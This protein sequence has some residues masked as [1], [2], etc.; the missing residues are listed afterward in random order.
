M[1]R[2]GGKG[3]PQKTHREKGENNSK[4]ST[5]A[6]EIFQ[7]TAIHLRGLGLTTKNINTRQPRTN[8]H[9]IGTGTAKQRHYTQTSSA[10]LK[11][12]EL[13]TRPCPLPPFSPLLP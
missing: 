10:D 11:S 3:T 9:R 4:G 5:N 2:G 1:N 7:G 12:E 13:L 6:A 8:E